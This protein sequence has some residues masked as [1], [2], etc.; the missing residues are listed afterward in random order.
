VDPHQLPTQPQPQT[1]IHPPE[2]PKPNNSKLQLPLLLVANNN[3]NN[4]LQLRFQRL[5]P[6]LLNNNSKPIHKLNSNK[7]QLLVVLKNSNNKLP[8][9]QV[10]LNSNKQS[11]KQLLHNSNKLIH[12]LRLLNSN[13]QSHK[14]NSNK[15]THKLRLNLKLLPLSNSNN[16]KLQLLQHQRQRLHQLLD[17]HQNQLPQLPLLPLPLKHHKHR[18]PFNS[19]VTMDISSPETSVEEPLM[20]NTRE[21]HQLGSQLTPMTSS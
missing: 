3:S 20:P 17:Q 4:K 2:R 6:L 14:L 10:V 7:S 21:S 8:Q 13:K 18:P 9:L 15:Q 11:H 5:L 12:K 19:V 1:P 16:N